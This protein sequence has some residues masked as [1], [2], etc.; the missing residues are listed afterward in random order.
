M[1]EQGDK[2]AARE[3]AKR[4]S[5]ILRPWGRADARR[6]MVQLLTSGPPFFLCWYASYRA[7]SV[8]YWLSLALAVFTRI[9]AASQSCAPATSV[10]GSSP[11]TARLNSS[12]PIDSAAP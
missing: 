10:P 1:M 9:A 8:S 11:T 7:L 5:E 2:E 3:S 12:T 4:W 6:S